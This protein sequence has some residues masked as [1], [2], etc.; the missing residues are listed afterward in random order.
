[1]IRRFIKWLIRKLFGG[2]DDPPNMEDE[3][4]TY[5]L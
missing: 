1:M 5:H 3:Q 2:D 4:L